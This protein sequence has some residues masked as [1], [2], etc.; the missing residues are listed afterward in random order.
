MGR[1]KALLPFGKHTFLENILAAIARS[2]V[3]QTIV[4]VGHHRDVIL[5]SVR[6]ENVVF[7]PDYELGMI[8]SIQAGIR[9]LPEASE[10]AFLFLVDH[11]VIAS[12][13]IDTLISN[14]KA[15]HIVLP[16]YRGRR[17]HPVLFSRDVLAEIL[18]LPVSAAANMVVRKDPSRIIEVVVNDPGV[19][20]DVDTP[21]QLDELQRNIS[22]DLKG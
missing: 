8:T 6:L 4:V 20:I 2:A 19:T 9:E 18:A 10:G 5:Q 21:E 22:A 1:A 11:P 17:G 16:T 13:T 3:Q 14:F 12:S 7:N 15:G